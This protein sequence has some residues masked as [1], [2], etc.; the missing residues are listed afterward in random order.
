MKV[1]VLTYWRYGYYFLLLLKTESLDNAIGLEIMAYEPL[2]HACSPNMVTV[3]VRSKLKTSW[4]SVVFKN[5]VG[6]KSRYFVGVLN[7]TIIPLVVVGYD[8]IIANSNLTRTH[9]IIVNH[10]HYRYHCYSIVIVIVITILI[11]C[12]YH[13]SKDLPLVSRFVALIIIH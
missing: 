1:D 12:Y 4:K 3:C 7:K 9:G 11:I 10:Y 8:M 6:E 13:I 5:K 2:Y